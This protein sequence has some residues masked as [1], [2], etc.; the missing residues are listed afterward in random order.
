MNFY[1][2]VTKIGH[3]SCA[4]VTTSDTYLQVLLCHVLMDRQK[5]F[6]I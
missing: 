5:D 1:M 4:H 6:G 2:P 3:F